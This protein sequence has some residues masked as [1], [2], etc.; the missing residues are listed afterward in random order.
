MVV[1]RVASEKTTRA[2]NLALAE[3][4]EEIGL[5]GN[6][7]VMDELLANLVKDFT[8]ADATILTTTNPATEALTHQPAFRQDLPRA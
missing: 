4:F 2:R 5:G 7:E 6:R 8:D 3:A 1:T